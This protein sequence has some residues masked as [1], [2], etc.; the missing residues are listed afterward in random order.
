VPFSGV[1][2][3]LVVLLGGCTSYSGTTANQV[4]QWAAQSDV[5]Y[6]NSIL[7]QDVDH[8]QRSI[9]A[10]DLKKITTNCDGLA[11]DTGTAYGNLP[12][13]DNTLTNELNDAYQ[14]FFAAGNGCS[15]AGSVDSPRVGRALRDSSK[16]L[17]LLAIATRHLDRDGVR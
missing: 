5:T 10:R 9:A 12:T 6:N 16:G 15:Q 7:V 11:Y 13:P 1:A 14:R 17:R 8:L 2:F 3:V 4:R